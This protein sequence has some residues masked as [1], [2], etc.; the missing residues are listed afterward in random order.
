MQSLQDSE[1]NKIYLKA[2]E[3]LKS[4]AKGAHLAV[5]ENHHLINITKRSVES[6]TD[7]LLFRNCYLLQKPNWG[8]RG[9]GGGGVFAPAFVDYT[10]L[11]TCLFYFFYILKGLT[12]NRQIT[13][14][15]C[16]IITLLHFVI[17]VY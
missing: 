5:C 9:G 16:L 4:A 8:F 6:L 10:V 1:M 13:K 11:I 7:L 15:F 14:L 17:K 3:D 12:K 2:I